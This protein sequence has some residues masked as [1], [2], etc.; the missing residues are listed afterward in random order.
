M[1]ADVFAGSALLAVLLAGTPPPR[2]HASI[3]TH[4][5]CL[6]NAADPK[7]PWALAHGI[8]ALGP[9]YLAADGRKASDVILHDFL[10]RSG[11]M[12][13]GA[14]KTSYSFVRYA[15]DG[16][17]VEPHTNLV[18]KTLV[19]SGLP[20]STRFETSF[21][22]PITLQELADSA[23]ASYRHAPKNDAAWPDAAWTIDLIAATSK[24][25]AK[26][27]LSDGSTLSVDTVM[28]DALEALER[29]DQELADGLA[30]HLP[31]VDKR[32]QGIYAHPCGGLHF[33]QAVLS[34][35][36]FPEVRKRWGPRVEAQI[37]V[38]LYRL[39]SERR[40]YESALQQAPQYRLQL[41][42]QMLKFYGHFLE[43]TARLKKELGW[44]PNETQQQAVMRAKALLDAAVRDLDSDKVWERLP[45]LKTEQP[46]VYLDLIGDS[47]H[48]AHGMDGWP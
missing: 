19:L 11:P 31:Q 39:D 2:P 28:D 48:A 40:Q 43:T 7:N 34:W 44:K 25:G 24:P 17:P 23:K 29:A 4:D 36:R 8:T 1:L 37:D 20:M 5:Q 14:G 22:K 18:A 26:L 3:V 10:Q 9:L 38:L 35:A 33:V 6:V 12:D 45:T 16:T 42:V 21:G 32:K 41:L 30:K 13:G 47:C 27:T 15:K 46:Q